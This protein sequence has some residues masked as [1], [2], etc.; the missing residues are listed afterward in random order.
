[1]YETYFNFKA[2]PFD[3]LP[4]PDFLYLSKTHSKALTYL[5]Y[6]IR[7]RSGFILLTGEVGSGKTTIVRQLLKNELSKVV[8]AKVFNTRVDSK[9]LITM[10]NDD[11]GLDTQNKDKTALIRDLNDFLIDQYAASRRCVLVI[12]EAQN[13]SHQLLEEVRM[14]SNLETDNCK[15]LQIILVGQPELRKLLDSPE[16]MQLRQR[17]QVCCHLNS[18]T[19]SE[20]REYILNRLGKAGNR[21]AITLQ[22]SAVDLIHSYTRGIPRLI[23]ILCDYLLLDMCVNGKRILVSKEVEAIAEDLNFEERFWPK[24]QEPKQEQA[25]RSAKMTPQRQQVGRNSLAGSLRQIESRISAL[26]ANDGDETSAM[27]LELKGKILEVERMVNQNLEQMNATLMYVRGQVASSMASATSA[28]V[29]EPVRE[30]RSRVVRFF[31][32]GE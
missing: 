4:N 32:G 12:D 17:I 9:Q 27:F 18:L 24:K 22:D 14:L 25:S 29:E 19:A 28:K 13:L 20:T 26:E 15:L 21:F 2:K 30:K 3:L 6:G 31:F 1:M 23:N 16:L 11:Y 7:E 10:I 8:L 5:Q